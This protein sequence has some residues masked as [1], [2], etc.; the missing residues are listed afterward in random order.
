VR[1]VIQRYAT[2]IVRLRQAL[3]ARVDADVPFMI[4]DL[5]A[6]L[7]DGPVALSRWMFSMSADE[8]EGREPTQEVTAN[9]DE[10]L[11]SVDI[12]VDEG[13]DLAMETATVPDILRRAR[14]DWSGLV[15]LCWAVGLDAPGYPDVIHPPPAFSRAAV[16][17][18]E[19]A[20]RCRDKLNTSGLLALT[21][22]IPG[23]EWEGTSID[24]IPAALA[25]VALDEYVEARAVFSWLCDPENRSPWQ[26][27]LRGAE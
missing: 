23:F 21:K 16:M 26:E 19:R 3:R 2:R 18:L 24:L 17:T 1:A 20:W 5:T 25:S 9:G 14:A 15:W 11:R 8:Y 12:T 7:P 22:G 27:D 10:A 6:L 13:H 4:P